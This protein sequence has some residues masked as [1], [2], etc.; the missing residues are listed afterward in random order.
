LSLFDTLI[1]VHQRDETSVSSGG[2]CEFQFM[3]FSVKT[4][5]LEGWL[6]TQPWRTLP[7]HP[8]H[9]QRVI[10]K[11]SANFRG[12]EQRTAFSLLKNNYETERFKRASTAARAAQPL[13]R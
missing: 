12:F 2:S 10:E 6:K 9:F 8:N 3:S 4:P 13:A 11:I 7:C 1:K 5:D